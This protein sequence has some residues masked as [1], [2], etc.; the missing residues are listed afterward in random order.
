MTSSVVDPRPCTCKY[1]H[2]CDTFFTTRGLFLVLAIPTGAAGMPGLPTGMPGLQKAY[3][4]HDI[5]GFSRVSRNEGVM[6]AHARF[7]G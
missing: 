1:A 5:T 7:S 2:A 4:T 6:K 3:I